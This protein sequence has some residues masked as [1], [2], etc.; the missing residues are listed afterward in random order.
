MHSHCSPRAPRRAESP[1][2]IRRAQRDVLRRQVITELT[3]IGD[4]YLAVEAGQWGTALRL[5]ERHEDAMRLL[6]D[7]GWREDDPAE[8]FAITTDAARLTRCLAQLG[9]RAAQTIA[10]Y[11]ETVADDRC[12]VSHATS[13]MSACSE[14]LAQLADQPGAP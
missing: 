12:E 6:D 3:G 14:I 8:E 11:V 13:V 10:Q 9:D 2:A 4:V 7:L 5:R 1:L